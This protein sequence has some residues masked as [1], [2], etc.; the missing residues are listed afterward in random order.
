M[1]PKQYPMFIKSAD[2]RLSEKPGAAFFT[3]VRNKDAS[4]PGLHS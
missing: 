3:D 4:S 2:T 1:F